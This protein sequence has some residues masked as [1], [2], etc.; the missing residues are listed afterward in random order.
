MSWAVPGVWGFVLLALAAYRMW[1]LLADDSILDR[2][3]A[4]ALRRVGDK[5][6]LFL[7][8]PW[9]LGFWLSVAWWLAWVA[10]PH[11]ALVAAVPFALSAVVG[12]LAV[13]VSAVMDV[14]E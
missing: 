11:W 4:R 12:A 14:G 7:I 2:P 8:C 10:W 5:G 3:R 1:K 6:E 9:C 13:T